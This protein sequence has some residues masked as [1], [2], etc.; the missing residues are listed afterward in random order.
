MTKSKLT[1]ADIQ[2]ALLSNTKF[3]KEEEPEEMPVAGKVENNSASKSVVKPAEGVIIEPMTYKKYK[4]LA[5]YLNV[6]TDELVNSA[7]NH[8]LKLKST[9][10][11][12]AILKLTEE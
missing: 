7:L 9:Q 10:L 3:I 8:F 6:P 4:I 2:K 12:Q 1:I 11:E 5:S